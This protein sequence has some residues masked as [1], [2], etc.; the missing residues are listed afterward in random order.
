M[1]RLSRILWPR[2][3][4]MRGIIVLAAVLVALTGAFILLNLILTG[5]T[6]FK[7]IAAI[8]QSSVTAVAITAGGIFA[9]YKLQ[10]FRDL[11][12]H[13]TI[14]H[15]IS[16]RFIGDSYVHIAVTANLRN[17]SRVKIELREA[18]FSLQMIAPL[19]D[20]EIEHLF[21][22]T[23]VKKEEEDIQWTTLAS[24]PRRWISNELII[25]PSESHQET[26]EFILLSDIQ[27]VVIYTYFYNVESSQHTQSSEGWSATTVYDIVDRV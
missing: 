12:P 8:I 24:I 2:S 25:E 18:F 15:E 13:L 23:F 4:A 21:E 3:Q 14:T 5:A 1:N 20:R 26:F 17:S 6:R 9:Y 11:Q 22:E 19:T 16:H 10:L 7:D 27:S